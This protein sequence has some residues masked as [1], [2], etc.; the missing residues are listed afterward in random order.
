MLW[1]RKTKCCFDNHAGYRVAQTSVTRLVECTLDFA[2]N[3]FIT[4]RFHKNCL[5]W[6]P[7][8]SLHNSQ[9]CYTV[10]DWLL[11][12]CM[13]IPKNTGKWFEL[14]HFRTALY[15]T[16][17]WARENKYSYTLLSCPPP[18]AQIQISSRP[19]KSLLRQSMSKASLPIMCWFMPFDVFNADIKY[20]AYT[21]CGLQN[22]LTFSPKTRTYI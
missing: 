17:Y 15:V 12:L 11:Q 22:L 10:S 18:R 7:P 3:F 8:C 1:F 21:T 19:I 14:A 9:R 4:Y 16:L 2:V 13:N 5:K 6:E 20:T